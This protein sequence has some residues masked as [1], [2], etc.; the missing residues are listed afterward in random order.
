MNRDSP[1]PTLTQQ[2]RITIDLVA[3]LMERT[4]GDFSFA[5]K[6]IMDLAK[7]LTERQDNELFRL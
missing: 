5:V 1:Q 2:D 6:I 4:K 7:S 3:F